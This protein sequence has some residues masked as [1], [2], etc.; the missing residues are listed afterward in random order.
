MILT[1]PN[2][3]TGYFVEDGQIGP[4]GRKVRCAACSERWTAFP[5]APATAATVEPDAPSPAPGSFGVELPRAFRSRAEEER[6]MRA[7][8]SAGAAWA[9]LAVA[10]A[11]VIGAGVVFRQNVVRVWPQTASA[12]SVIGL[13]VNPVGLVI[14]SV[15]AEPSLQE[16]HAVLAVSGM[17]RNV[18]DRS[19][20]APPLRVTL[21]NAQ[22]KRVAG[23]IDALGNANIPP[24]E[25]RHFSTAIVDPPFSAHDLEVDFAAGSEAR[26]A[27]THRLPAASQP[28]APPAFATPAPAQSAG[29]RGPAGG[30][31]ANAAA[32]VTPPT[33]NVASS[34]A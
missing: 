7:A 4:S 21:L 23:Q 29:L 12:Y 34:R 22:G 2:C 5:E 6:R 24:G 31:A 8:A 26:A 10:V 18:V 19:V 30:P 25:T 33:A 1:C 27:A 32:P 28:P 17:I 16:G 20:A 9:G 3:A 14:E 15:K 11:V 13:P